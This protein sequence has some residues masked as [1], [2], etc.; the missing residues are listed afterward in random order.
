MAWTNIDLPPRHG[1]FGTVHWLTAEK[2]WIRRLTPQGRTKFDEFLAKYPRPELILWTVDSRLLKRSI[3]AHG[4]DEVHTVAIGGVANAVTLFDPTHECEL[5]TI[6][7]P[8][9]R[10][11]L[12]QAFVRTID[13]LRPSS[14]DSI[15]NDYGR[16]D[17]PIDIDVDKSRPPEEWTPDEWR[18]R[19]RVL[20]PR[21]A[22][23]LIYLL[24][25]GWS[26]IEVGK[27]FGV[28]KERVRQ[29]RDRSIAKL[30]REA[31]VCEVA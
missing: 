27:K 16:S 17:R 30:R 19:L 22:K 23:M 5:A 4:K 12:Q 24:V 25:A 31:G 26:L 14:L 18:V 10:S 20:H 15:R 3:R 1:P 8:H 6:A 2:R 13:P 7:V 29:L 9:I 11:A 21:D 28:S